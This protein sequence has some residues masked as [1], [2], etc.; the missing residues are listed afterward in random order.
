MYHVLCATNRPGAHSRKVAHYL[1]ELVRG[2]G[3]ASEVLDLANLRPD[4]F[5]QDAYGK[6]P[7]WFEDEFQ[8]PILESSGIIVVSPEYNGSF[9]GV[10]KYFID[11]LRF[12]ESLVKLPVA[13]VGVAAGQFGALRAVEQLQLVFHYRQTHVFGER[14]FV[15]KIGDYINGESF[16]PK[17]LEARFN[18][19]VS[20]FLTFAAAAKQ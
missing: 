2:Q 10:M 9:P 3:K 17:E 16:E 11:M 13:F 7:Q 4:I 20:G 1:D 15:S 6:K 14:I 18:N 19:L 5:S 12:P 8:R